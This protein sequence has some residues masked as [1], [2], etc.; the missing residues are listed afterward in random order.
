[1]FEFL[2]I[3]KDKPVYLKLIALLFLIAVSLV[4]MMVIGLIIAIPFFGTG[5]LE[6]FSQQVDYTDSRTVQFLKYFQ[7]INQIGVFIL[8]VIGYAFLESRKVTGY[9]QINTKP[10]GSLLF[11][12]FLMILTSIPSVNWMIGINEKMHLPEFMQPI[13]NWMRESEDNLGELTDAFLKTDSYSGLIVNMI[14]I[15]LLAAVGEEF[16][17]RGVILRI[18]QDWSKNSH[19]A[20]LISSAIFSAFHMQFFGFL[21]RLFLG[22][23][24]GYSFISTGSLWTP[25]ILHFIFN[26]ISVTGAFLYERGL[27]SED[28][29]QLGQV[30]NPTI[31]ILSFV[32]STI[33]LILI[34]R[35]KNK[36]VQ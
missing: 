8:P 12:S 10:R 15:A 4:L 6:S 24:L 22:I 29:A 7:V 2:P 9:L 31:I 5:I 23:L 11:I 28:T 26:G 35:R 36:P 14:I 34:F 1:M 30:D 20:V 16:L 17:F 3:L 13:E 33:F 32:M 19:I 21:P 25:I 18:F 27:I